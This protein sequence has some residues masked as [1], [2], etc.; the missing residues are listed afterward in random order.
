VLVHVFMAKD[1]DHLFKLLIIGDSGK[2]RHCTVVPLMTKLECSALSEIRECLL[3]RRAVEINLTYT[4][5]EFS[6]YE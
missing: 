5:G 4:Y 3:V 2:V 6:L 1:Y